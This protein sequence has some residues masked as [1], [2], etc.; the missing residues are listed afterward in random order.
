MDLPF[1]PPDAAGVGSAGAFFFL[2]AEVG[3]AGASFVLAA[4]PFVLPATL[5]FG[6]DEVFAEPP[7][8][9]GCCRRLPRPP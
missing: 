1:C 6:A 7:R 4:L 3:G 2:A 5:P 9:L 8:P